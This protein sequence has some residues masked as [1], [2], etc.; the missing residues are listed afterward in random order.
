MGYHPFSKPAANASQAYT[1]PYRMQLGPCN[2]CGFCD[3]FGCLNYSKSS[4]QTCVLDALKQ[5]TNFSYRTNSTV[6]RIALAADG[7]SATGVYYADDHDEEIL[8]PA[9][10]VILCAWQLHNVHLLLLSGIGTPYDP[11]TGTGAVGKN[12]CYQVSERSERCSSRINISTPSSLRV[13]AE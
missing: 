11:A 10:L 1:N 3:R 2:Y 6:L 13:Q 8:Q 7:K 5:Y 4:P 9:D 12:Y